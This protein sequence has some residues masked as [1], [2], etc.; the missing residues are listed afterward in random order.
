MIGMTKK[1]EKI[2]KALGTLPPD[3]FVCG[4]L[5]GVQQLVLFGN[6]SDL[7]KNMI[8]RESGI[9][10]QEFIEAQCQNGFEDKEMF[11]F[12]EECFREE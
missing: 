9:S 10:K 3:P 11:Q 12:L 4:I 7:A 5:Y 6:S 8:V 1:E 2:Q